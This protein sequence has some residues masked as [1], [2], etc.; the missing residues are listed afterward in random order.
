MQ[1]KLI[2][3]DNISYISRSTSGNSI[4]FYELGEDY[5]DCIEMHFDS[6]NELNEAYEEIKQKVID[7]P[8]IHRL[9]IC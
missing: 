7:L 2:N 1:R 3:L 9:P 4:T 6:R 5:P 8:N